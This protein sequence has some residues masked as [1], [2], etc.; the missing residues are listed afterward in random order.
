[1]V[2]APTRAEAARRLGH[3]LARAQIHGVSTNRELLVRML[4]HPEFQRGQT[5]THFLTRHDPAVLAAPL[6]D[7]EAE[8]LH[9]AAAA[10][11]GQD[12]RRQS[13]LAL[14]QAPSGWR[15]NPSAMQQTRFRGNHDEITIEY[16]FLRGSLQL[17]IDGQ[18]QPA[19]SCQRITPEQIRLEV[20]GIARRYD[21]HRVGDVY[22]VDSPLG[23]SVLE[24]IPRFGIPR[25]ETAA[26]SL[27][28]PLPGVVNEVKVKQEDVVSAGD[29]LLV[30]D[31]MKVFH[32]ISAPLAG[33]I[34]EIRV[35][36][37]DQVEAGAVLVVIE[38]S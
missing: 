28:A 24:E 5:D 36:A 23:A 3:A 7:A 15:N 38:P 33:R 20:A 13:A 25:D 34:S 4:A 18:P 12:Q 27:V 8:G 29:V 19:A 30:I 37:G 16:T 10:L 9:A 32:W 2:H 26:G 6:A 21:V 22:Y 14:R 17:R 1:M 35:A 11:A 31:S